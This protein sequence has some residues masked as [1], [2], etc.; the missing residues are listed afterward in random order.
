M[1]IKLTELNLL[2]SRNNPDDTTTIKK[3]EEEITFWLEEE[4]AK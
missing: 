3:L 2:Q 4:G 1:D